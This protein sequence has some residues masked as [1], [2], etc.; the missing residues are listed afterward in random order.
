MHDQ[1][2]PGRV[3]MRARI[4]AF[5]G[6][7]PGRTAY[8]I[9]LALDTRRP[10][11]TVAGS[12]F[13]LLRDM[14]RKGQVVAVEEFRPQ[15]GRQVNLWHLNPA[16]TSAPTSAPSTD[17]ADSQ[18]AQNRASV[19]R[20]R[21]RRR[22][23][24]PPAASTAWSLPSD[25]ACTGADP[26]LFFPLPGQSADPA[27]AI[28]AACQVRAACLARARANGERYGIWGGVDFAAEHGTAWSA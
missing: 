18:S 22:S 23:L 8:E 27:K 20:S 21:V 15:Q 26:E 9:C 11:G 14:E 12:V 17:G 24:S 19:R 6:T 1:A 10:N 13:Q 3:P 28:C 25:P 5:L 4:L 2:M 16:G 7:H